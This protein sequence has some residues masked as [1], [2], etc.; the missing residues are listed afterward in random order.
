MVRFHDG[1]TIRRFLPYVRSGVLT[2]LC[3]L[4]GFLLVAYWFSEGHGASLAKL[5]QVKPGMTRNE[6][7]SLLGNPGTI[8]GDQDGPQSWFY[9]RGTFCQVKVYLDRNGIVLHTDHDH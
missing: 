9:T 5:E 3:I 8:D 1:S 4:G 2:L 7:L 6:V